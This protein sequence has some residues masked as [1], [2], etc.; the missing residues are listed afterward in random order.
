MVGGQRQ[1]SAAV[2]PGQRPR[3][4]R[5]GGCLGPRASL[6]EYGKFRPSIGIRSPET[7]L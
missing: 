2:S 5:R 4:L 3:T 6:D 1:A 7:V